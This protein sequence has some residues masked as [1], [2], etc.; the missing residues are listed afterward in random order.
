MYL[1]KT[2]PACKT[3]LRFPI[4]KGIIRV[5]CSCGYSF[6]ADPDDTGIYNNASFDLSHSSPD[7]KKM[8]PLKSAIRSI[9]FEQII[10]FIITGAL[11]IKY[12]IL[13]FR[14]L[15]DA[16]KKKIILTILLICAGIAIVLMIMFLLARDAG[17]GEK[18]II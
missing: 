5:R 16:E 14:L 12:K 11:N 17:P 2:C 3:R 18:I 9:K 8:S 13:N 1:I 7:L 6:I 15:P 10:P 4:D